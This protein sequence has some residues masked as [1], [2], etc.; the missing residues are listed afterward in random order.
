MSINEFIVNVERI[1][2]RK[3]SAAEEG[4]VSDCFY[5]GWSID[6]VIEVLNK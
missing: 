5:A 2:S 1:L 3:L 6:R 4:Y